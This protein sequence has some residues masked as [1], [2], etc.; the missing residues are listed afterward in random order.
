MPED[1]SAIDNAFI[2]RDALYQRIKHLTAPKVSSEKIK[3]QKERALDYEIY[4]FKLPF[5]PQTCMIS[6]DGF[7][8]MI[9]SVIDKDIKEENTIFDSKSQQ[10]GTNLKDNDSSQSTNKYFAFCR[11]E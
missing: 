2:R 5:H 4:D 7:L 11:T 9:S 10:F 3:D 6:R 1:E 8:I